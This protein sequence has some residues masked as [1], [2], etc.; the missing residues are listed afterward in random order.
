MD[1][2]S[3][4]E[5]ME[6]RGIEGS[7]AKEMFVRGGGNTISFVEAEVASISHLGNV[8]SDQNGRFVHSFCSQLGLVLARRDRQLLQA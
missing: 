4:N 2:G 1:H 6:M 3:F 8:L 5:D 7:C